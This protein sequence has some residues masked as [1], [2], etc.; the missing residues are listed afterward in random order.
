MPFYGYGY[1]YRMMWDPTYILIIVGA[2]L[3]MWAS[4]RGQ[5]HFPPLCPGAEHDWNDGA[6]AA[7]RLLHSQGIYD[8]TV[9]QVRGHLTDHYDPRTKTVNLSQAVY[10]QTSVAALGVAA[11]ECGHAIQ[12][13]VGYAPLRLRSAFVPVANLGSTLSWP[14]DCYWPAD[15][16]DPLYPS[17]YLDV[18]SGPL[19]SGDYPSC[20]V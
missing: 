3:S 9:R 15:W 5:Q 12:D 10:S 8:V 7:M 14:F 16:Y 20:G 17:G 2:L 1:G 19:V 13:N 4:A 6:E 18:Y 11:H